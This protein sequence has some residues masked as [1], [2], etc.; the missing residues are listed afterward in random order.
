MVSYA[1]HIAHCFNDPMLLNKSKHVSISTSIR[2]ISLFNYIERI[3]LWAMTDNVDTHDKRDQ[4]ASPYNVVVYLEN[5][6]N[7]DKYV[8]I[9]RED[10]IEVEGETIVVQ[11]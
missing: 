4:Q 3:A 11:D 5:C 1:K 8:D 6:F 7:F 2:Y 9:S 10:A